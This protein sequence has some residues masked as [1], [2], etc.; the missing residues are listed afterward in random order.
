MMKDRKSWDL[1]ANFL[2]YIMVTKLKEER[3][4]QQQL[5]ITL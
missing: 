2:E 3:T 4:Q 5:L 1:I